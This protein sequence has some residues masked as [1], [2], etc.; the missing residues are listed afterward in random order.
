MMSAPS[1][2]SQAA[3]TTGDDLQI[4]KK[5]VC[6]LVLGMAGS[7]KTEFVKRLSQYDHDNVKPYTI[8][9][10]PAC[11]ETPYPANIGGFGL[12]H[13]TPHHTVAINPLSMQTFATPSTTRK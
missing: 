10:D 8:N 1:T 3:A 11:R 6:I 13:K 5:P 7:G 4:A 12:R 9:L 2:S